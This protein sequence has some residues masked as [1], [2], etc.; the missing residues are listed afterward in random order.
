MST[1]NVDWQQLAQIEELKKYFEANFTDFQQLIEAE[2][3][4]L[5]WL[6]EDDLNQLSKIRAIEVTNG[7]VQWGFRRKDEQS[8]SVDDTRKCMQLSIGFI[9]AKKLYF[10][11]QGTITFRPEVQEFIDRARQLYQDAFKNNVAGAERKYYI[12]STAQFIVFGRARMEAAMELV[13]Q[14]YEEL[15]SPYYIQRGRNYI[16]PYLACI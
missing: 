16:A 7:C 13:K 10:P 3:E 4:R 11:S 8:L 15:F 5:S 6:T 2:I 1:L 14:D 12:G 9:K